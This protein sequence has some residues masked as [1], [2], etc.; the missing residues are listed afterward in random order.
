MTAGDAATRERPN[1]GAV[2]VSA[3]P[4]EH[5]PLADLL[6]RRRVL[7]AG[8]AL[9]ALSSL[10]CAVADLRGLLI[11]LRALQGFGGGVVSPAPGRQPP[12]APGGCGI[13]ERSPPPRL[14]GRRRYRDAGFRIVGSRLAH[15]WGPTIIMQRYEVELR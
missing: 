7:L 14:R 1:G 8:T 5:G 4:G 13:T 9:F 11:G 6:G 12:P 2:T 15:R 3:V 10:A